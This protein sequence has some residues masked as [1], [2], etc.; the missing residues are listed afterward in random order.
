M[1]KNSQTIKQQLE[2]YGLE[3]K[4]TTKLMNVMPILLDNPE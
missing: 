2:N 4:D 3:T 1:K